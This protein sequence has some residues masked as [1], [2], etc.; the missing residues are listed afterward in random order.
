MKCKKCNDKTC[1]TILRFLLKL[2]MQD[3]L[4]EIR[5]D[6]RQD[7]TYKKINIYE[8]IKKHQNCMVRLFLMEFFILTLVQR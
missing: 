5:K 3:D 2:L 7:G 6:S 8:E 1:C 4:Q